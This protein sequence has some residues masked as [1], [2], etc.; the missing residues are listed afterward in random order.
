MLLKNSFNF[1]YEFFYIFSK[2]IRQFYLNSSIYNKKISKIDNKVLIYKPSLSTLSCIVKYEKK[3]NKIENFNVNSI[4]ENKN[5]SDKDYKKIHSFYWLFTIDLKSSN[6]ITQSIIE[7]W[8]EN[9]QIYN[10]K[11][12]EIEI[13]RASCR[14]RV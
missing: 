4:W 5:I 12:W 7:N 6:A 3:K 8:I 2:Q 10:P 9:N 11:N 14:E 13:G 1:I